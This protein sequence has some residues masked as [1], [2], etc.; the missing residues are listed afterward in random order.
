MFFSFKNII[1]FL[2]VSAVFGIFF[3]FFFY[4]YNLNNKNYLKQ[5]D[6]IPII[7]ADKSPFRTEYIDNNDASE[8]YEESCTLNNEC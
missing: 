4:L 2:L 5:I 7:E 1:K 3:Y 8:S 6:T